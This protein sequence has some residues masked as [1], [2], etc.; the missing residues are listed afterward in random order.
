MYNAMT[1][2]CKTEIIKELH[3]SGFPST[4]KCA[5]NLIAICSLRNDIKNSLLYYAFNKNFKKSKL[6]FISDLIFYI[7][8]NL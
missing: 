7:S 2:Q 6:H 1:L 3:S 8:M 4:G 5:Y